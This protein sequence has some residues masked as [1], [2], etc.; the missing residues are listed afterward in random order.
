MRTVL[1]MAALMAD[2]KASTTD[3]LIAA[4]SAAVMAGMMVD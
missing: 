4:K 2:W 3:T 1:M